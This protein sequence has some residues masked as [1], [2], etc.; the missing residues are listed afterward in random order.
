MAAITTA[1]LT[2]L[3]KATTSSHKIVST[4]ER[5]FFGTRHRRL[6]IDVDFVSGNAPHEWEKL[7]RPETRAIYVETMSNPLLEVADL[8]SVVAFADPTTSSP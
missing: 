7:I 2:V 8:P 6:G 1:L 3:K 5:A 4:A